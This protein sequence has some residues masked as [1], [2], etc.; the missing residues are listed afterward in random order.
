[1]K[2]EEVRDVGCRIDN[3][4]VRRSH[5]YSSDVLRNQVLKVFS[6]DGDIE[7]KR[8]SSVS[9]TALS[10]QLMT[11]ESPTMSRRKAGKTHSE[12][13]I[14]ITPNTTTTITDSSQTNDRKSDESS[15]LSPE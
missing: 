5:S 8:H 11:Q 13:T 4:G 14:I 7:G 10:S 3:E 12:T 15:E 1:M 6:L 9:K 2:A